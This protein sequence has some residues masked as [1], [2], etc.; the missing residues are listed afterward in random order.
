MT[1][2]NSFE[3]KYF[4]LLKDRY[5]GR[6]EALAQVL[7]LESTLELPKPT[8]HFVSDLHGEYIAFTHVL[9]NASGVLRRY[10]DELFP[11]KSE[12][13]KN[14]LATILYYPEKKL[15][16]L[17]EKMPVE[18][19]Q[20]LLKE[21]LGDLIV[22]AKRVA[23]KYDHEQI[24][25]TLPPSRKKILNLLLLEDSA[26]RHKKSYVASLYDNMITLGEAE[27]YIKDLADLSVRYVVETVHIIGDIYD[28]GEDAEKIMDQIA[29]DDR[30]DIQ[31]GN[32][33][34]AWIGAAAGNFALAANVIRIALRYNVLSTI[35]DG[36]GINL[37]PLLRYAEH[38]TAKEPFYTKSPA[39][40]E[41]LNESIAKLHKAMA[42]LQFKAE[43]QLIRRHPAY[44]MNNMLHLE[45][46]DLKNE[47]VAV[48][49]KEYSLLDGDF[50]TIDPRDPYAFT[51]EEAEVAERIIQ[52]F[53]TSEKLQSH[54][55]TMIEKGAMYKIQNSNLLFHGCIPMEEDG[56]FESV[57]LLGAPME[58]RELLDAMDEKV[59][60]AFYER[61]EDD[62][63][64]LFYLW[65]GKHSPLFGKERI[66]TF[67]RYFIAEEETHV[68]RKNP[69]YLMREREDAAD[70]ILRAFGIDDSRGKIINGHTPVKKRK[71]E[72]PVKA[73]GK[74]V[75]IDGG[76][77]HAYR[78]TTGT[79][80][81]TL[82]SN[83]YGILLATHEPIQHEDTYIREN[84]DMTSSLEFI[85]KY[86][87]RRLVKDTD[88][89][90]HA[91]D[92]IADL[93]KLADSYGER[94]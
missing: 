13:D 54:I 31:W 73:G 20:G 6:H 59:R 26:S 77:A 32:H 85:T 71:G 90:E 4:S 48:E 86:D 18:L 58:G 64:F 28:R 68:E 72:N 50:P 79:A 83:S 22:V 7:L 82:I 17:K 15:A 5:P 67:E 8:E 70:R 39:P 2:F 47:T 87:A 52:S 92:T 12:E 14:L 76:F 30:V 37:L 65:C 53:L 10:I 56:S 55:R 69:Y 75:V 36:Y 11:E 88:E 19:Y 34:I 43:G 16:D 38:Y 45:N 89:G 60:R 57:D 3:E 41:H 44:E 61:K 74:V 33:D 35:E 91:I 80:G 42:I 21:T 49:G 62:V 81:Y 29:G 63:D 27:Y 9:R 94:R 46:L 84:I 66:T 23:A 24:E 93:K 78:K 1:H 51:K 25:S 40:D